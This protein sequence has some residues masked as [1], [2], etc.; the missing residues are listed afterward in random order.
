MSEPVMPQ[1]IWRTLTVPLEYA[2][3]RLDQVLAELLSDLSRTR[4]KEWIEAGQV[5]VDG[6]KLRP[7]DKVLGGEQVRVTAVVEEVGGVAAEQIELDVVQQDRHIFVLNKPPGLVV[8]PG[9]GNA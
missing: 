6:E 8:H 3:Q 1:P 2:G 5:L 7:K 9:A 4:I